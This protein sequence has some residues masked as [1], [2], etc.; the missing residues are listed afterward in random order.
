MAD[1]RV[2]ITGSAGIVGKLM[3]PRLRRAGRVLRLLDL[4]QQ[5]APGPDEAVEL[6]TASVT[7]AEAMA[8]ACDGVD[9]LIHLGGLSR[10]S[11]WEDQLRVNVDGTHTLLEAARI[12]GI[13]RVVLASS[14]HAVGFRRF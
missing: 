2:L 3:R 11:S 4:A 8:K 7:D 9:A 12:A 5:D 13:T 14:S 10:E 6:I 1:Q